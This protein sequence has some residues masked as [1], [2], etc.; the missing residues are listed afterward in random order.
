MAS[1]VGPA[2]G[3]GSGMCSP[4]ITSC[5]PDTY[6]RRAAGSVKRSPTACMGRR[7]RDRET[8]SQGGRT[9]LLV[10]SAEALLRGGVYRPLAERALA[11]EPLRP[12]EA[13][14][15]LRSSDAGLRSL[16]WAAFAVRSRHWGP[17]L[18]LFVL[19]DPRSRRFPA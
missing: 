1:S 17:R 12:E 8:H 15:V 14:A 9:M 13:L 10:D 4:D 6:S 7:A 2:A 11:D 16:L 3:V 18:K 19:Q 5:T